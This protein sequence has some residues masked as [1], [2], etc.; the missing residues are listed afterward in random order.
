MQQGITNGLE[1]GSKGVNDSHMQ[2]RKIT[3]AER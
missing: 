1:L 3:K 2:D